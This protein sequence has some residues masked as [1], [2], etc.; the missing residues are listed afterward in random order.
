MCHTDIIDVVSPMLKTRFPYFLQTSS[1]F[2]LK[3]CET[4]WSVREMASVEQGRHTEN[5]FQMLLK[6]SGLL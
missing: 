4:L 2:D 3:A 5:V 1:V 6:Q